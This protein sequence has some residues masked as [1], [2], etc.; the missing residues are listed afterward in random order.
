MKR[1]EK[2]EIEMTAFDI[3]DVIT[4]SGILDFISPNTEVTVDGEKV[5]ATDFGSQSFSI[6]DVK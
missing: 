4:V 1:Y 2:P 3:E 6:F 5:T